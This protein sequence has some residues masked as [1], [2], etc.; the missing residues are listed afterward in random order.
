M[1]K[2]LVFRAPLPYS[3]TLVWDISSPSSRS[4]AYVDLF[5]ILDEELSAYEEPDSVVCALIDL[6]R[7]GNPEACEALLCYRRNKDGEMF[8]EIEVTDVN[9]PRVVTL[10]EQKMVHVKVS[11]AEA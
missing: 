4:E 11:E 5:G 1:K 9:G 2:V 6:A 7:N 10:P 8:E 3:R